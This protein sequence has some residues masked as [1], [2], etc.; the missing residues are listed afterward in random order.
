MIRDVDVFVSKKVALKY[1]KCS[2]RIRK[3]VVFVCFLGFILLFSLV[4]T[5]VTFG[6]LIFVVENSR[7]MK[8]GLEREEAASGRYKGLRISFFLK[9]FRWWVLEW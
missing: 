4:E 8:F 3:S 1:H 7:E 9:E 6:K 2:R 5:K